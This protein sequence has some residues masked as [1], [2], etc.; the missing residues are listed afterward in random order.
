MTREQLGFD[1]LLAET[2]LINDRREPERQAA[3]LPDNMA[4]GLVW[5]KG[6]LVRHHTAM[7]AADLTQI[8]AL[9][10]EADLLA[11][12]LNGFESG[13]LAHDD[14]PGCVLERESAAAPGTIP[15]WGQAG[16]FT[17]VLFNIPFRIEM[18]GILGISSHNH[19]LGFAVHAVESSRPFITDTGYRSFL[20]CHADPAPGITPDSHCARM[21]ETFV[22]HDLG[23]K[24]VPIS[25][26]WK[27]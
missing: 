1:G 15:T 6:L 23:G 4:D 25:P 26:R 27:E 7:M 8:L 9:R 19:W 22:A 3:H 12:K 24:L 5:F 21:I 14:A 11:R 18:G 2:D 17:L 20:G 10:D 13:I 16:E